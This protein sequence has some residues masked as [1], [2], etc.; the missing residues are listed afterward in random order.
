VTAFRDRARRL[1]SAYG[2]A[3]QPLRNDD[4]L[5]L[6]KAPD[7]SFARGFPRSIKVDMKLLERGRVV[8]G[9]EL[10][11]ADVIVRFVRCNALR[12]CHSQESHILAGLARSGRPLAGW[13]C[14]R[15][16]ADSDW[17]CNE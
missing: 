10:A 17:I 2:P 7:G 1:L 4:F 14:L 13:R 8:A 16:T 12:A 15:S 9:D 3:G 5:Y 11:Q 6:G